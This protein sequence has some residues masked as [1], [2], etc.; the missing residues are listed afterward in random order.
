[1][2]KYKIKMTHTVELFVEAENEEQV[3][4]WMNTHTP[5]EVSLRKLGT[6]EYNDE[7][8]CPVRDDSFIDLTIE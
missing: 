6:S 7:I 8:V 2:S 1:M 4:D 5:E 3:W